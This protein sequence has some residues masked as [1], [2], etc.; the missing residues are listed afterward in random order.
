M[1]PS[2][3]I[4]NQH[5]PPDLL[6]TGVAI[7]N[8]VRGL[9]PRGFTI[10][11]LTGTPTISYLG[12]RTVIKKKEASP[13]VTIRRY[14]IYPHKRTA[15]ER[16]LHYTSYGLKILPRVLTAPHDLTL[17]FTTPPLLLLALATLRKFLRQRPFVYVMQDLYPDLFT[18]TALG[19]TYIYRLA[20][21]PLFRFLEEH[22]AHIVTLTSD[23]A[24]T[25]K[26]RGVDTQRISVIP[27]PVDLETLQPVPPSKNL[28]L[29][30]L[31]PPSDRFRVVYTGNLGFAA[32]TRVLLETM[33]L[34]KEAPVDFYLFCYGEGRSYLETAVTQARLTHCRFYDFYPEERAREV[35]S[36][37]DLS[38]SITRPGMLKYLV[39]AKIYGSL[40]CGVPVVVT[41]E[42]ETALAKMI[43]TQNLGVAV[44][45][46]DPEALA[47][48][49]RSLL[50]F[51][52][53]KLLEMGARGRAW[54][55][56]T[57]SI[58]VVAEQ[59]SQ[60]LHTLL[61][62]GSKTATSY[63]VTVQRSFSRR[64]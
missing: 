44:P 41:A 42:A 23:M 15:G 29:R 55:E 4:L 49:I 36:L 20:I 28:L 54:V 24:R 14:S 10:E 62:L 33:I 50:S 7:R 59:Y 53:G 1:A 6:P 38:L 52:R 60:L 9:L 22:A 51:P 5:Y 30:E 21:A 35:I 17:V 56:A 3:L 48:A 57:S 16:L 18:H 2:L 46:G 11:I 45:P 27:N 19:D 61:P 64:R 12:K 58:P 25:L 31:T 34:L 37:G 32:D 39:P 8:L 47:Q 43:R 63:G 26:D 13:S 40:A